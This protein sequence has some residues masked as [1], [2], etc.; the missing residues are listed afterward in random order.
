MSCSRG[1]VLR[2]PHCRRGTAH[3]V[4][5]A[6]CC[7]ARFTTCL[8]TR[9]TDAMSHC[10]CHCTRHQLHAPQH[11]LF[12]IPSV[13]NHL[14]CDTS[15]PL[16]RATTLGLPQPRT[17]RCTLSTRIRHSVA[18]TDTDS[19]ADPDNTLSYLMWPPDPH[20]CLAAIFASQ[21]TENGP[22]GPFFERAVNGRR[23]SAQVRRPFV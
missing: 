6:I 1:R 14:A 10:H 15:Q 19:T 13:H 2:A 20:K 23:H 11:H 9:T 7:C 3:T 12:Q 8:R 17:M 4:G 21:E 5:G 22:R 16:A 18:S